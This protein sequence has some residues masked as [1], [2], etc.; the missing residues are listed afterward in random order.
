MTV[1]GARRIALA[2]ALLIVV[3]SFGCKSPEK[4]VEKQM[5]GLRVAWQTN[6]EHQAD[7]PVRPVDW[8]AALEILLRNNVKLRQAR[9]EVTNNIENYHQIFAN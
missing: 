2:F 3:I 1:P 5:G 4:N 6:L 8:P 9:L 7:L